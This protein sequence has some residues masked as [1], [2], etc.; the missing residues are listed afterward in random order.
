MV[1]GTTGRKAPKK[2]RISL[3]APA[4][5]SCSSP[6]SY[7]NMLTSDTRQPELIPDHACT[8]LIHV[9]A[10]EECERLWHAPPTP[11]PVFEKTDAL[12][13]HEKDL[14]SDTS[15]PERHAPP[16]PGPTLEKMDVLVEPSGGKVNRKSLQCQKQ[17][18]AGPNKSTRVRSQKEHLT[19]KVYTLSS[20]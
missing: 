19:R 15:Q 2:P 4:Y 3:S 7:D 1:R 10:T 12:V 17:R 16:S 20:M 6:E 9:V 5:P 13:E 14:T 18:R 8:Q 11:G